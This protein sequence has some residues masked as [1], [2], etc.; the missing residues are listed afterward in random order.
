M[1]HE[2]HSM[3]S[4]LSNLNNR[5]MGLKIKLMN[6][7]YL[8]ELP[9]SGEDASGHTRPL[10]PLALSSPKICLIFASLAQLRLSRDYASSDTQFGPS[11]RGA[12]SNHA[13]ARPDLR[14]SLE[15]K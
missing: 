15:N 7:R 2:I 5:L 3:S 4:I 12:V 11:T 14:L 10:N 9:A 8:T 6:L 1:R 13:L